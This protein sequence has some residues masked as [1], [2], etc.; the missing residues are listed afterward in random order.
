MTLP[1]LHPRLGVE[2]FV[3]G[4]LLWGCCWIGFVIAWTLYGRLL[5]LSGQDVVAPAA[6]PMVGILLTTL[7]QLVRENQAFDEKLS[8][9]ATNVLT[10]I[11]ERLMNAKAPAGFLI[12]KMRCEGFENFSD[13]RIYDAI[14]V[15]R[16]GH[17]YFLGSFTRRWLK[18]RAFSFAS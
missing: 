17:P 15:C 11:K 7:L 12:G 5:C 1:V 4:Y 16:Q 2:D 8:G 6:V 3:S 18:R 14:R 9:G 13:V 10:G